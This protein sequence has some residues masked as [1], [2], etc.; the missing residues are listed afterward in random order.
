MHSNMSPIFVSN[1]FISII[2]FF[3]TCLTKTFIKL[4]FYVSCA[5]PSKLVPN[6]SREDR[7]IRTP[8]PKLG[9]RV[10]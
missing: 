4:A 5:I 2:F 3:M 9:M 8:P 1:Y 7:K 6:R 10:R